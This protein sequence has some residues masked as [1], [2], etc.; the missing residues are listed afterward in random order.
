[1]GVTTLQGSTGI[2][3]HAKQCTGE[4]HFF[5]YGSE[6]TSEP[7]SVHTDGEIRHAA[8]KLQLNDIYQLSVKG[9]K[10]NQSAEQGYPCGHH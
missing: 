2:E 10:E 7:V 4:L 5:P 8:S 6:Q 9:R 1:M 3:R